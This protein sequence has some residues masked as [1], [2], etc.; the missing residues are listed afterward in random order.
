MNFKNKT[1]FISLVSVIALS[2]SLFSCKSGDGDGDGDPAP[3]VP[4]AETPQNFATSTTSGLTSVVLPIEGS[5]I[6]LDSLFITVIKLT[7]DLKTD[8]TYT[9][10]HSTT[11]G[12]DVNDTDTVR[13]V[14]P[15]TSPF[16]K[17]VPMNGTTYYYRLTA[18]EDSLGTSLPTEEVLATALSRAPKI[19]AGGAHTCTVVDVGAQCWGEGGS[20]QLGHDQVVFGLLD[21]D[22]AVPTDVAG[23]SMEVTQISAGGEHTCAVVE[24]GALCWGEGGMAGWETAPRM[25]WLLRRSRA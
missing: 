6:T 18:T 15:A 9:L 1:F 12:F 5:S 7:W 13:K 4:R 25:C 2:F 17:T 22:R 24:G 20:G 14:S 21:S 16:T 23:L 3:E 8:V 10:Y 19:S 11:K